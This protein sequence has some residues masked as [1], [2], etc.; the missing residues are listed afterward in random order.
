LRYKLAFMFCVVLFSYLAHAEDHQTVRIVAPKPEST[1]HDNSGNL[2]VTVSVSLQL[3]AEA[4][5]TL[6]LLLDG[7][8]VASGTLRHFELKGVDRGSH[9]LQAQVNAA[10][11]KVLATSPQVIFHMWRA[12]R[13]FRNRH[14]LK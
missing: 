6:T 10:D 8:V 3:R 13:L 2:A 9:T 4:G 11:G 14:E 7:K 12:S 1:V 5:D